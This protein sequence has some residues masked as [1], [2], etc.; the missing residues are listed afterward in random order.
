MPALTR[1]MA[2]ELALDAAF[3]SWHWTVRTPSMV[4]RN[5]KEECRGATS[6]DV[7]TSLCAPR[8]NRV[9]RRAHVQMLQFSSEKAF[10]TATCLMTGLLQLH[11]NEVSEQNSDTCCRHAGQLGTAADRSRTQLPSSS[12]FTWFFRLCAAA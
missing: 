10:A 11:L 6:D 12:A 2:A 8:G 1:A 3:E 9:Q 7:F 4:D 5:P